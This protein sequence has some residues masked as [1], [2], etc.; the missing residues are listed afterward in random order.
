MAEVEAGGNEVQLDLSGSA[1]GGS[2]NCATTRRH[3]RGGIW[4]G[5]VRPVIRVQICRRKI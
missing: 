5:V 2:S 4:K 1:R 3:T